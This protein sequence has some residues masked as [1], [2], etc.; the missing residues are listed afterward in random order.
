MPK[1]LRA[2]E[3]LG[4]VAIYNVAS[5]SSVPTGPL[6]DP[7]SYPGDVHFHS[8]W[9]YPNIVTSDYTGTA[10]VPAISAQTMQNTLVTLFAHGQAAPPMVFG[11]VTHAGKNLNLPCCIDR[12]GPAGTTSFPTFF[13]LKVDSTN[14]Y[15]ACYGIARS[16]GSVALSLP[17]NVK[18]TNCLTTGAVP[19]GDPA[20]PVVKW[21][22]A[23]SHLEL[24][25]GKIDTRLR[26]I[27]ESGS[28]TLFPMVQNDTIQIVTPATNNN[29]IQFGE[30]IHFGYALDGYATS[31]WGTPTITPTFTR[32]VA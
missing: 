2:S 8:D 12:F 16:A 10:S 31:Q 24:G 17:Y 4:K 30:Y 26:Y 27:R 11:H 18:V 23:T 6:T 7:D 21:Y 25:R 32:A 9:L 20:K 14:V 1:V 22:T 29:Y 19:A 5:L 13:S 28:G 3:S 15:L